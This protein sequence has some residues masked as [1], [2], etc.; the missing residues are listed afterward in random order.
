MRG[1]RIDIR[2]FCKHIDEFILNP[3]R[4]TSLSNACS[5]FTFSV[6]VSK[7]VTLKTSACRTKNND[8]REWELR[9]NTQISSVKNIIL[10]PINYLIKAQKYEIQVLKSFTFV[11]LVPT[12][13]K[14][15]QMAKK[16][17]SQNSLN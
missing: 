13:K 3:E 14:Q 17:I 9:S 16:S 10:P 12:H 1:K 15:V 5:I 7:K 11:N 8:L 4:V 2:I 6:F